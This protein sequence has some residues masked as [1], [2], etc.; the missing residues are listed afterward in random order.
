MDVFLHDRDLRHKNVNLGSE[1]L[2]SLHYNASILKRYI[3]I[4]YI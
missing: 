3:S 2:L 1:L 4:K